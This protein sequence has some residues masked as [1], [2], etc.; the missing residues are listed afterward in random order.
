[1]AALLSSL[2]LPLAVPLLVIAGLDPAIQGR[3]T[4]DARV[5]PGHD[6]KWIDRYP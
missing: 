2:P 4:M 1:M 5:K 3:R 6:K